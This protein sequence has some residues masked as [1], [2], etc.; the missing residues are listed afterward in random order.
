MPLNEVSPARSGTG[1]RPEQRRE[2]SMD[3]AMFE[4]LKL[5]ATQM[6]YELSG[7]VVTAPLR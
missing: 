4:G 1:T 6:G 7:L 3:R 5:R 2:P